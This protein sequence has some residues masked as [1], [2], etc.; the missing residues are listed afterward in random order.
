MTPRTR[1]CERSEAIHAAA[2]GEGELLPAAPSAR[3]RND[4]PRNRKWLYAGLLIGGVGLVKNKPGSRVFVTVV[5]MLRIA[6]A[7]ISFGAIDTWY[8]F[9][10][11]IGIVVSVVVIALLWDSRANAYFHRAR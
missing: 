10:S 11:V 6:A 3:S 2:G 5:M 7:C 8:S 9:G 4:G 1:H